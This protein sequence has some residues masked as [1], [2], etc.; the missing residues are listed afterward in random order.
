MKL[1]FHS[2]VR[3]DLAE[4]LKYYEKFSVV[5]ANKFHKDLNKTFDNIISNPD[6]EY[7][8]KDIISNP[9]TSGIPIFK[10]LNTSVANT[11]VANTNVANTNVANTSAIK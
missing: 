11:N 1:L 8:D 6:A 5:L 2:L 4:A 9:Q 3:K 7:S 10:F